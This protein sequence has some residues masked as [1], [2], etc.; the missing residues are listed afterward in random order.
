MTEKGFACWESSF[1]LLI[2]LCY[3]QRWV[4]ENLVLLCHSQCWVDEKVLY[5]CSVNKSV[6]QIAKLYQGYVFLQFKSVTLVCVCVC[7]FE[8]EVVCVCVIESVCVVVYV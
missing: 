4:D 7:V 6:I 3:S 8:R 5:G 1:K 2:L